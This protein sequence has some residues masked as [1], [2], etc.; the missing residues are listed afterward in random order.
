MAER[1]IVWSESAEIQFDRILNYYKE[2]NGNSKYS[3]YLAK[4][5]R[6]LISLL[7]KNPNLGKLTSVESKRIIIYGHFEI[8]YKLTES[9]IVILLVWDTRRD[10]DKLNN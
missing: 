9:H 5:I 4:R 7:K 1:K 10:P 2:R 6:K 3:I 8:F